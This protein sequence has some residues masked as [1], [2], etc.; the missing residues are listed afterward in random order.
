MAEVVRVM[1]ARANRRLLSRLGESLIP[2]AAP[3]TSDTFYRLNDWA[4]GRAV[5]VP[6]V[7]REPH[8]FPMRRLDGKG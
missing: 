6:G 8:V 2:W 1:S 4:I 7:R 5:G 3:H